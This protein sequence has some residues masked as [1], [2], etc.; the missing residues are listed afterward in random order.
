MNHFIMRAHTF[1]SPQDPEIYTVHQS[2]GV[3]VA[4]LP[5]GRPEPSCHHHRRASLSTQLGHPQVR[6]YVTLKQHYVK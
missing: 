2:S 5:Q 1:D 3:L 4:V 6:K